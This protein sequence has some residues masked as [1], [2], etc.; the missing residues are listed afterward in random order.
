[1]SFIRPA[2]RDDIIHQFR[3]YLVEQEAYDVAFQFIEAVEESVQRLSS[4]P[5]MGVRKRSGIR[6]SKDC[7]SGQ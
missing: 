3:W 2:A 6:R 5:E 1:M 7:E 4:M